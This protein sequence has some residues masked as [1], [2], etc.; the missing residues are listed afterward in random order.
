MTIRVKCAVLSW[1]LVC[2][3]IVMIVGLM[4]V[5]GGCVYAESTSETWGE[6]NL[7]V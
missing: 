1:L 3:M 6:V 7:V 4:S 2:V 5:I